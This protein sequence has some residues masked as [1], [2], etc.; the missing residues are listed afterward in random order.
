MYFVRQ[1]RGTGTTNIFSALFVEYALRTIR[2]IMQ[3]KGLDIFFKKGR[4]FM[5]FP[6]RTEV[7]LFL[8]KV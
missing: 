6:F 1:E 7:C 5:W 3:K 2:Y 4:F 8:N